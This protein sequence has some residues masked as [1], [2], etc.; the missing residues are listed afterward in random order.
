[1]RGVEVKHVRRER[2]ISKGLGRRKRDWQGVLYITRSKNETSKRV[3]PLNDAALDAVQRMVTTRRQPRT[4]GSGPLPVVREPASQVR[5]DEAGAASGTPPGARC[6][7]RLAYRGFRFH[8]LRH[9]VVTRLL[10]AGEPDHVVESITGHLSRRMLEHYSHQR[11]KAKGQ[12][13]TR[14]E[15]R[16]KEEESA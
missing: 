5:S 11:L 15:E 9:T 10:E 1:M 3:I 4:H 8:D 7:M 6:A 16:R 14:M 13:L 12:M 2:S